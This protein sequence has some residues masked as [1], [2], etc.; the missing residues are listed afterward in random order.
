MRFFL[1]AF[2]GISVLVS[3]CIGS[4]Q[5][6]TYPR[7]GTWVLQ[8]RPGLVVTISGWADDQVQR[9]EIPSPAELIHPVSGLPLLSASETESRVETQLSLQVD[10]DHYSQGTLRFDPPIEGELSVMRL[11]GRRTPEEND[12]VTGP[13]MNFSSWVGTGPEMLSEP[14]DAVLPYSTIF[15]G[16]SAAGLFGCSGYETMG[17]SLFW[18]RGQPWVFRKE[19]TVFFAL[20][21]AET[22]PGSCALGMQRLLEKLRSE[23]APPAGLAALDF[24]RQLANW[25]ALGPD[26]GWIPTL[27][28]A[29]VAVEYEVIATP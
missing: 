8:K 25:N 21:S 19:V 28:V 10:E 24:W 13:D 12:A 18:S 26:Y 3:G 22:P 6:D 9:L 20:G 15:E 1:P 2:L 29:T 4:S 27:A 11:Q 23:A 5:T 7:E 14:M 16:G 17:W